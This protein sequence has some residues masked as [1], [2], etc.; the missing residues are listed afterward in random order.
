LEQLCEH[1]GLRSAEIV[2]GE[3]TLVLNNSLAAVEEGRDAISRFLGPLDSMVQNRLEVLFEELVS[4]TVRHGFAAS[5]GQSIH[6]VVRRGPDA[7]RLTFEDDGLPFDPTK[8]DVTARMA[9]TDP[10][11]L[12]GLGIP[13]IV[14]LSSS[15]RYEQLSPGR[16]CEGF[17]PRNRTI[18]SVKT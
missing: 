14:R 17:R 6:V 13:L 10:A 7:I 11:R 18:V 16:E 12:G 3:L 9:G 2:D 8:V 15:L 1:K 4:N 5:S